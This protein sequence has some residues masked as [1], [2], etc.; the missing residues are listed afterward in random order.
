LRCA[1][2]L[3]ILF[4]L[5]AGD[6]I[7]A[8]TGR[9]PAQAAYALYPVGPLGH[10]KGD[11]GAAPAAAADASGNGRAGAYSAGATVSEA[12]PPTKFPNPGSI[13][14]DGA[15]GVV[16]VPD[17]PA[18]RMSGD[19]TIAFWKRRTANTNDWTRLVGKGNPAQR[20]FGVWEYPSGDGRLKFQMYNANGGSILEVD[21][22][23]EHA[24]K[25]DT[26][27]HAVCTLSG[28]AAALYLN[29]VP[30][31]AGQRNGDPGVA[32]D[33][34]TFGYAG[35]PGGDDV[36]RFHRRGREDLLLRGDGREPGRGKRPLERTQ[37]RSP[38]QVAGSFD[39]AY[40]LNSLLPHFSGGR[41]L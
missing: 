15:S 18:L 27:Y 24:T 6:R 16:S 10:W 1:A 8:R 19:F 21:S 22:P 25:L 28:T 38:G 9:A 23:P 37:G 4:C 35:F 7:E 29:G 26:W 11:D 40:F 34:L 41:F 39:G 2:S 36:C 14:L 5:H 17:S 30:V 12:L 3:A 31:A 13:G 20:N 33:P 32:A